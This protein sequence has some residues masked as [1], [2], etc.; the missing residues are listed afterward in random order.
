MC[1]VPPSPRNFPAASFAGRR[2]DRT[3]DAMTSRECTIVLRPPPNPGEPPLRVASGCR[4]SPSKSRFLTRSVFG[5]NSAIPKSKFCLRNHEFGLNGDR[6]WGDFRR[7]L[8]DLCCQTPD[9]DL[10]PSSNFKTESFRHIFFASEIRF[11]TR[12]V[13]GLNFPIS[14]STCR[15][16]YESGR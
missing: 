15:K 3:T 4:V 13:F 10:E 16:Q 7:Q 12:G 6:G 1:V 5:S 8:C 11:Q 14:A 2:C 9:F